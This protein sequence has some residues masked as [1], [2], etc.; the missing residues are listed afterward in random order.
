MTEYLTV[1][2]SQ[3]HL[4]KTIPFYFQSKDKDFVL[5]KKGGDSLGHDR[6][7]N[8]RHPPLFILGKDKDQALKELTTALNRNLAQEIDS[9]GFV[10]VKDILCQIVHEA[11]VPNQEKAMESLPETIEILLG[12]VN[13]DHGIMEYLIQIAG[14]SSRIVEHTVNVAALTL[15]YC[16]S[17]KMSQAETSRLALCAMLHDVGSSQVKK[18]LIETD[19]RLTDKEFKAFTQ[20]TVKG[21]DIIISNTNF[22]ISIA[23][24]ALE[25]HERLDGSG[26]PNG[27]KEISMDSQL[28]GMID[29]YEPLTYRN[30]IFRKAT[31]PFGSLQIIKND[32]LKEKFS[33]EV[34]KK[35]ASCLVK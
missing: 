2:P 31:K 9:G 4:F 5:Y 16:F 12:K 28:M 34:F 1:K 24:V 21:Y 15:Q 11:L 30:K 13:Q 25:H 32:V 3:I 14:N 26:Y 27:V 35:F 19:K 23:T 7:N 33:K 22:D 17:H 6:A 18:K 8:T 20:H 10:Q 29:S